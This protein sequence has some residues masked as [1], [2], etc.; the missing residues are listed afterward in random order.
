MITAPR[1]QVI[2]EQELARLTLTSSDK[3]QQIAEQ[4]RRQ[5]VLSA[6]RP[7]LGE[8]NGLPV[9]GPQLPPP[10]PLVEED[11]QMLD[12]NSNESRN[13]GDDGKCND[14]DASSERTLID[15]SAAADADAVMTD[16]DEKEQ[17]QQI[18]EDKEN[19]APTKDN[20]VR[21]STP[22]VGLQPLAESSPSRT[23]EQPQAQ[24]P[25]NDQMIKVNH[26][27]DQEMDV[28]QSDSTG[29][30]PERNPIM[31]NGIPPPTPKRPPPVPP[32]PKTIEQK[33]I[34]RSEVELGAQ[35]DVTEVIANVLF[36]LQ[37]AIKPLSV[38]ESGEQI[39]QIK[40]MFFGK[41]KTYTINREGITRTQEEYFSDI[42]IDVA[43][44]SRDLYAAL[45][46]AFDVQ[47]VEVGGVEEPQYT[48][49]SQLPPILQILVQRAQY[50]V[51]T[52]TSFKSN[53]F[54]EFKETIY[55]DRYMDSD[56]LE[57]MVRRKACW[58]WKKLLA[59]LEARQKDL[60]ASEV[61][62][63]ASPFSVRLTP[64]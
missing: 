53:H 47:E 20:T 35:Q 24:S 16:V 2:P 7:S 22:D 27:V 18:F 13:T 55:M 59:A 63:P 58:A 15:D 54:L 9:S 14:G 26:P 5:S 44:G 29:T 1:A 49:I 25:V 56:D 32:R 52:K 8:I 50:D 42:K 38:D 36:Q 30:A 17:Q 37:C 39:D 61:R 51:V 31:S 41:Q 6:T 3:E 34:I 28:G 46:G 4:V 60:T 12:E 11:T 45:D 10:F 33:E 48:T 64:S 62:W 19:L 40:D 23:N 57:L 43:S 21:P